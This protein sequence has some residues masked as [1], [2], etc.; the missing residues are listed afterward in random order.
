[1]TATVT[2]DMLEGLEFVG[3]SL[4]PFFLEDPGRE[5][6]SLA[7]EAIASIDVDGAASEWPFVEREVASNCLA[8]MKRAVLEDDE[9]E[10][11]WEYRRLFTGPAAR[12]VP[13]W[14]SVYMDYDC[15]VFGIT[16]I[17]LERWMRTNG[18]ERKTSER[19]PEDHIGLMLAQM[20][21]L[22]KH[23]SELVVE[24][25]ETHLLTWSHHFFELLAQA[26]SNPFYNALAVLT[27][28]SLEGFREK[29]GID[30]AYPRYY[31]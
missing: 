2:E 24:Y 25:M 26:T 31:R 21:Y 4:A 5:N 15:V 16:E 10:L 13:P 29:A 20:S 7:F 27:D 8:E 18:V 14:G 28:A 23:R 3:A 19:V 9:N 11:M 17:E 30:V 1:M 22:A 12:P 6:A